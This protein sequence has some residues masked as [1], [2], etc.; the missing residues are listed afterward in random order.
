LP[1]A[2]I[3]AGFLLEWPSTN[4]APCPLD[5]PKQYISRAT[6]VMDPLVKL[7]T[8]NT[9]TTADT[10]VYPVSQLTQL[11][12]PDTSTELPAVTSILKTLALPA[13]AKS[14]WTFTAGYFN[15]D[16]LLTNLLINTASARG[17]VVTA[18]PWANGFYGS[19]GI[20]G[21]L[22]SAYT[23]LA[24]RFLEGAQRAKRD[25]AIKLR[26]WRKGTVGEP[27]AWTYHA[28]GFWVTM[29][30]DENPSITM[31]GSSNYTKRSYNLD[32]EAN[33]VVLT[34]DVDL[35]RRLGEEEK[36]LQEHA[37]DVGIDDFAKVDRRVGLRVRIA[38]W[39]VS[40]V[41]GAL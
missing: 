38:M 2:D 31:I 39:I 7:S 24:R 6:A 28:K 33:V 11:L 34:R 36:W 23:L 40:L 25:S 19:K 14:S 21:L 32:L 15:P 29:P 12:K 3:P 18:S 20:S 1:A 30:G 26:E 8:K 37:K 4:E 5:D 16:P 22:P 9:P 10:V 41:G 35:K 13:F 17:T 27:G